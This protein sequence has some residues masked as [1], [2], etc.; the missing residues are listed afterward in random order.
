MA[1]AIF[2]DMLPDEWKGR[3]EISSAGTAAWGGQP[4]SPLAVEVL[5][6]AGIDLSRHRARMLTR[7]MIESADL[8]V[9]MELHHR[10]M[11]GRIAPDFSKPVLV[12]GELDEDRPSP[13]IDDPIGGDRAAYEQ[14]NKELRGLLKRLIEYSADILD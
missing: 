11:I 7:D 2:R 14:T 13:D 9:A 6:D 1:E 3:V 8:I 10:D 5:R 12:L 4:A